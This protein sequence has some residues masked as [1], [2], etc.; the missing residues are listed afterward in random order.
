MLFSTFEIVLFSVLSFC[1]IL[2]LLYYWVI[3]AKPYYYMRAV[4]QN[5]IKFQSVQPPVSVIVC[6]KNQ[7]YNLDYFLPALLGQDYPEFEVIIVNDGIS[8][9]NENTLTLLKSQYSNLYS[10][11]IPDGT[12]SISRKKLGL[13]LGIKAAKY[14]LLLFT[15]ADSHVRSKDWI[16]LMSR[17][18]CDKKSV[19]LGFSAKEETNTFFSKFIAY[20][21]FFS[22]LQMF[23]SALFKHPYAGYGRNLAYAKNHFKAQKGFFKYLALLTGEDDLFVNEIATGDNTAIELS[24]ES[25]TLTELNKYEWRNQ[26]LDLAVTKRYYKHGPIAFWRLESISRI[27]FLIGV[28]TCLSMSFSY[29]FLHLILPA[30]AFSYFLIRLFTQIFVI[31][32]TAERLKLK[33]TYITTPLFDLIQPFISAYFNLCSLFKKKGELHFQ[34]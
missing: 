30:I 34:V 26:K 23:S 29:P 15:E 13:T 2:Q 10:T 6:I 3:L 22:N 25:V 24:P 27:G 28:I 1:F 7:Y 9:Q 18:F 31:N 19:V 11:Y 14:D 17:H 4:S 32:K 20:D 5:K 12:K 8:D 33:K 16:S 21:Y